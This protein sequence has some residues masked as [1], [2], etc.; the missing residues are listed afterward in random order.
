MKYLIAILLLSTILLLSK[1]VNAQQH[2]VIFSCTGYQ[3]EINCN[4]ECLRFNDVTGIGCD[5]RKQF[6]CMRRCINQGRQI[7]CLRK[8]EYKAYCDKK[9]I[10]LLYASKPVLNCMGEQ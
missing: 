6:N 1:I 9:T 4:M 3:Q 7:S 8:C 5:K 2:E 10:A